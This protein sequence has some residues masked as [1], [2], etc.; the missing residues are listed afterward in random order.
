MENRRLRTEC[1]ADD[2]LA[3]SGAKIEVWPLQWGNGRWATGGLTEM[4]NA[5]KAGGPG[6][7]M[8]INNVNLGLVM[9]GAR[10]GLTVRFGKHEGDLRIGIT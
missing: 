5:D 1:H 8:A 10:N 2:Q 7:E 3:D 9:G 4:E 6:Q